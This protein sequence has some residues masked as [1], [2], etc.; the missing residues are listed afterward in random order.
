MPI[1]STADAD[2]VRSFFADNL[3]GP[4]TVGLFTQKRSPLFV[5][6][7]SQCE[8]CEDAEKLLGELAELSD[9]ITL[10]LHDLKAEPEAGLADAVT[11]DMIPTVVLHGQEN[12]KLRFL[13]LPSG[14][15]FATLIQSIANVS[16]GSTSLSQATRDELAALAEDVN[17]RVFVTPT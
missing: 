9:K 17:I 5:P 13:G 14:Y 15:E 8:T 11:P 12:G 7:Q 16:K 4:V 10:E 2:Q 1:L 3:E 6:G